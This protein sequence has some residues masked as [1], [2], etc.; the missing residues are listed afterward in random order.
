MSTIWQ[1]GHRRMTLVKWQMSTR[2][3]MNLFVERVVLAG[4]VEIM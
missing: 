4:P 2:P 1:S 3:D